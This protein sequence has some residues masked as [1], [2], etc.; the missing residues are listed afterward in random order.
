M[1]A[2]EGT[3]AAI[4]KIRDLVFRRGARTI[5]D[6]VS[7]D[8]PAGSIVAFMGPSGV[9]KTTILRLI[10]GQLKPDAG[11]IEVN[12]RHVSSMSS[13]ELHEMRKDLGFLLQNGA[14]FTDLTVFENVATPLREHS[15]FSERQ[16]HE[17]VTG[18]LEAVGLL[19]TEELMPHELSG[20]MARRV[21]LARAVVLDPSIVMFDEPL[22]GLDPIAVSTIRGLIRKTNDDLGLTSIVV[23]HNVTQM[24]K[25]ADYCYIIA[26]GRIAGEGPPG[27]LAMSS[28][29]AVDQFMN[30]KV[31]GPIPFRYTDQVHGGAL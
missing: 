11:T 24:M 1:T 15:D 25:L 7:L 4:I 21:A 17:R 27:E 26:Q 20:G 2:A 8:V 10:S 14:L 30:G 22:T 28:D 5:L 6:G 19:G 12:G 3:N 13:R 9:G 31:D 18:K 29:P 23:T 16:I